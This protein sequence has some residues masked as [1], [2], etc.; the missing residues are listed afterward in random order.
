MR[1]SHRRRT[2]TKEVREKRQRDVTEPGDGVKNV[3]PIREHR[4]RERVTWYLMIANAFTLV[5]LLLQGRGL[6]ALPDQINRAIG[7]SIAAGV[8]LLGVILRSR[9]R[10][11]SHRHK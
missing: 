9:S 1:R 11:R 5:L 10:N 7:Y 4:L 2:R 3:E 6:I 8:V